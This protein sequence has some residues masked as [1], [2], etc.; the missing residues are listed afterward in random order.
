MNGEVRQTHCPVWCNQ[1]ASEVQSVPL[2][3]PQICN[4]PSTKCLVFFEIHS[5]ILKRLH[6]ISCS[7][8]ALSVPKMQSQ[9]CQ[10]NKVNLATLAFC[11]TLAQTKRNHKLVEKANLDLGQIPRV[12]PCWC[13]P[14][15]SNGTNS[16]R[17]AL[18]YRLNFM[19]VYLFLTMTSCC[20]YTFSYPGIHSV[21]TRWVID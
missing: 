18:L 1:P 12:K 15:I 14:R 19:R 8:N 20:G 3:S 7:Q 4:S 17:L 10:Y 2:I 21:N 11:R 13:L 5:H 9:F 6:R 16:P